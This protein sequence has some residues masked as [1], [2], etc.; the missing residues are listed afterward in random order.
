MSCLLFCLLQR[1]A[2]QA[3]KAGLEWLVWHYIYATEFVFNVLHPREE[4]KTITI[5]DVEGKDEFF[6]VFSL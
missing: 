6:A 4:A 2:T 1:P 5:F 3:R